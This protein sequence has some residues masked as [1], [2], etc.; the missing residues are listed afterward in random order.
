MSKYR[1][2]RIPGAT[3]FFTVITA[4]RRPILTT[5]FGRVCLHQSL[6]DVKAEQ[7]FEIVAIVL[8]PDHLHTIWTLPE[9][10]DNYSSRWADVKSTFTKKYLAAGGVEA[11]IS[12]SRRRKGERGIWQRRFWEHC[13]RD[14]DDLKRCVDYVHYNPVKH[15]LVLRVRDWPWSSFAR[16]VDLGEYPPDWGQRIRIEHDR[17]IFGDEEFA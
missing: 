15:G 13:I 12:E 16:F 11:P 5:E 8:L 14:D 7:P 1:R 4:S 2:L 3:Y 6:A 17:P 9:G 10:D